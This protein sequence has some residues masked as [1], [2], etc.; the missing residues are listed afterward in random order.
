[1]ADQQTAI[2]NQQKQLD[3]LTNTLKGIKQGANRG[4]QNAR[5]QAKAFEVLNQ[6]ID[7]LAVKVQELI[8]KKDK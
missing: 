2:D 8:D 4:A 5:D 1:M 3:Q 7:A 6:K